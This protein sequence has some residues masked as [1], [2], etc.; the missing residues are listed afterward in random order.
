MSQP[1]TGQKVTTSEEREKMGEE[2]AEQ[3]DAL[4]KKENIRRDDSIQIAYCAFYA[5]QRK[6]REM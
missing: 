3:F 4:C 6:A 1:R 5:M 2:L